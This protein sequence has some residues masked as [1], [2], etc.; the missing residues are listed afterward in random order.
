[1]FLENLPIK[2]K[3]VGVILLTSLSV[4]ALTAAAMMLYD[5]ATFRG[6]LVRNLS[7]TGSIVADNSTA[8]L[9]FK[10]PKDAQDIL[11]AL[12]E[13][14]H[15]LAA[16]LY[17]EQ[18]NN[19]VHY[20]ASNAVPTFPVTPGK[21]GW[22][23]RPDR[24]VIYTPV[25]Q[26]GKRLGTLFL[27]SDLRAL[28]ERLHLYAGIVLAVLCGS[29][30]VALAISTALQK[31]IT[32][33][34]LALAGAAKIVSER[35]DYSVRAKKVSGDELGQLTDAFNEMLARMQE[36]QAQIRQMNAELEQRVRQRTAELTAANQELE[37]FT[38]SVAHDLRAPLRHVDAFSRMVHD[39]YAPQLP[40]EAQR[41]LQNIRNGTRQMSQLVDDLLNLARVSR[42]QLKRQPVPLDQLVGGLVEELKAETSG[43]HIQWHLQTLPTIQCDGGL[44]KQ[45]FAN[46]LSNAVKYTRPR[47]QAIIEVGCRRTNGHAAIY[48]RDN[49]VGFDMKYADKLFGVFQRLHRAEEFEGTG[50]GLAIVERIVR[51]HGGSIWA[52]AAVDQGATFFFTVR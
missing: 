26:G 11:N 1:M 35:R 33:P 20:P 28:S 7:I 32:N 10:V 47:S 18:G 30:M 13:D 52:E 3:V 27:E 29:M 48:V 50:V 17:D 6:T 15:I 23:F 41:Y 19:F 49:G 12:R 38:Y 37:A 24:L 14:P 46:L 44:I 22:S 16:A 40:A 42:Q 51:R 34:I 5:F 36:S 2:R 9:D 45:V 4:V 39:D 25:T 31:R 43:R 8:A 21:I